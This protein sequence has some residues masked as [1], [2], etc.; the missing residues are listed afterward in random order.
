MEAAYERYKGAA[1]LLLRRRC[2]W[3]A[4]DDRE[5]AYHDAFATLLEKH[6]DRRVGRG[7]DA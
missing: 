5:G 3:L 1:L 7:R 6:R 2:P 4:A